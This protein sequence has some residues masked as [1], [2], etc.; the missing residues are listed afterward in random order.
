MG[1]SCHVSQIPQQ[2]SRHPS[3]PKCR[4]TTRNNTQRWEEETY[5]T[6]PRAC[7]SRPTFR[8]DST[9]S[10][11][12]TGRPE[13]Q[14]ALAPLPTRRMIER[15]E[16][17]EPSLQYMRR[18]IATSWL[19]CLDGGADETGGLGRRRTRTGW[20]EVDRTRMKGRNRSCTESVIHVGVSYPIGYQQ[21]PEEGC[22]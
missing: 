5:R 13:T 20:I 9:T 6:R 21:D 11:T 19:E 12:K 10:T 16:P 15:H 7:T 17:I 8:L 18:H 14:L 4:V 2:I 1:R 22:T 3:P